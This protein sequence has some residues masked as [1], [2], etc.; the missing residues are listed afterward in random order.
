MIL[1]LLVLPGFLI[2]SSVS[3][4][5]NVVSRI[6][7]AAPLLL[8]V[9]FCGSHYNRSMGSVKSRLH[10]MKSQYHLYWKVL[11]PEL[12]ELELFSSS[13]EISGYL[14]YQLHIK[15]TILYF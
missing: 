12:P 13:A 4:I 7:P 2:I 5:V 10:D 6:V 11:T 14:E 1:W 8:V 9:G 15:G 3:G